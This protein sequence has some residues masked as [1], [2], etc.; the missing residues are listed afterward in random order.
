MLEIQV[1]ILKHSAFGRALLS[2]QLP[3]PDPDAVAREV[4]SC[5]SLEDEAY[6]LCK[7]L[8]RPYPARNLDN[9]RRV[10]NYRHSRARRITECAFGIL[11]QRWA[12]LKSRL[13]MSPE[14]VSKVVF[15]SCIL[16]NFVRR[17]EPDNN[18]EEPIKAQNSHNPLRANV[19]GRSPQ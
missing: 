18:I 10:Y 1:D 12:A 6:P 19:S 5:V 3:I 15:A 16:H 8:M 14:N 9:P 4:L 11:V 17:T 2:Q 13:N 7:N